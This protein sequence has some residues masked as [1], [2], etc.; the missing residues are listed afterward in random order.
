MKHKKRAITIFSN[1]GYVTGCVILFIIS[2]FIICST[3]YSI[4][5]NFMSGDFS[6]YGLLDE[7]AL[8]VFAIAVID[9]AKFLLIEEVLRETDP[10][11]NPKE[12]RRTITKFAVI[13]ATALALEGLV[14]TIETAKTNIENLL[15]PMSLL[16]VSIL[17]IVGIGVYQKLNS[18]S[19]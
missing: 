11:R 13:I 18:S 12:S 5:V 15:L 14:L 19:D 6:V 7:V 10:H 17:F 4:Y 9:V 8:I 2:I 1:I 16:V 3:V